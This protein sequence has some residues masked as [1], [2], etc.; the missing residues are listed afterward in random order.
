MKNS[1]VCNISIYK[2]KYIT[3]VR[4]GHGWEQAQITETVILDNDSSFLGESH[5]V[6]E[7]ATGKMQ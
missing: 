3:I 4:Y 7:L 5:I 2:R 6:R 1:F